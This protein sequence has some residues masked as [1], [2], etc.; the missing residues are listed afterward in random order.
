MIALSDFDPVIVERYGITEEKLAQVVRYVQLLQGK[1][2]PTLRDVAVGGYYGTSA[3]L[4]EVMELEMLLAREPGLLR[5]DQ[6]AAIEF[7]WA[8]LD[9]HAHALAGEYRY[10]QAMIERLFGERVGLGALVMANADQADFELLVESPIQ[11]PILEPTD[12]ELTRADR[13]L[14][15]MRA[16]GR[17]MPQ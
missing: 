1:D 10:L 7:F 8:N 3:L 2:A 5:F 14:K 17:E 16:L 4:H 11:V 9:A 6:I 12:S 15:Q 13:L